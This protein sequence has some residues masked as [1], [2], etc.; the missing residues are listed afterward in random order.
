M[1]TTIFAAFVGCLLLERLAPG[2]RVPAVRTRPLRLVALNAAHVGVVIAAGFTWE[3]W[4]HGDSLFGMSETLPA[5]AAG[6][7]AYFVATFVSCGEHRW[8]HEVDWLWRH[9]RPIR[10]SPQRFDVATSFG[11]HR[12]TCSRTR[13]SAAC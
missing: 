5:G 1:R 12:W 9:F 10:H 7:A 11:K 4:R 3:R 6:L 2:R 13:S 8:R